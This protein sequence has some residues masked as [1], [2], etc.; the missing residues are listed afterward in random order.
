VV[1]EKMKWQGR[2]VGNVEL[3]V[4]ARF[5]ATGFGPPNGRRLIFAVGLSYP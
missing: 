3:G 5:F 2:G 4:V 1:G